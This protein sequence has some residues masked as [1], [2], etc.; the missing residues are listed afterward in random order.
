MASIG[1]A[2]KEEPKVEVVESLFANKEHL[3]IYLNKHVTNLMATMDASDKLS[4]LYIFDSTKS[5]DERSGQDWTMLD[6]MFSDVLEHLGRGYVNTYAID[7]A[8]EHPDGFDKEIDL[9]GWCN[10]EEWEPAFFLYQPPEIRVNPYTGKHVPVKQ[11]LFASNQIS[12]PD[13][14]RW[15]TDNVPDYTQRLSTEED[16]EEFKEEKGI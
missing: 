14:K 8:A 10:R 1:A 16:A 7:C 9:K 3:G 6:L 12:D 4:L 2:K 11:V 15:I 5:I 13:V